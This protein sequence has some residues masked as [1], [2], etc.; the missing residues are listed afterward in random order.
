MKEDGV[1]TIES[2]KPYNDMGYD[3]IYYC[4]GKDG[5]PVAISGPDTDGSTIYHVDLSA[6]AGDIFLVNVKITTA[7][8]GNSVY[9]TE[10]EFKEGES[11]NTAIELKD[12]E[13]VELPEVE[14]TKPL[15]YV[16]PLEE[17][18]VTVTTNAPFMTNPVWFANEEDALNG[19]NG[20]VMEFQNSFDEDYNMLC[21]WKP[22][23]LLLE[24]TI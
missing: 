10:R 1:L 23:S 19:T 14:A 9:F 7:S 22:L 6:A 12:G 11:V 5:E 3:E 18:E 17:G 8:K 16:V 24:S 21:T 13:A 20:V 15:W 4:K 2:N